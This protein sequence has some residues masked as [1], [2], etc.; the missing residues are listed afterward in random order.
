MKQPAV[1]VSRHYQA[2][3]G[4]FLGAIFIAHLQQGVYVL[5]VLLC[6]VGSLG[7]ISPGRIYPILM[8]AALTG[9]QLFHQLGSRRLGVPWSGGWAGLQ[10]EDVFLCL[11]VLGYVAAHYR[12]QSVAH[13]ILPLD[14][15]RRERA[16]DG[17]SRVAVVPQRR[18]A[19]QVDRKEI[20]MLVVVLPVWAILG[21]IFWMW[22]RD[23]SDLQ[24]MRLGP[25]RLVLATWL[26][27]MMSLLA[28]TLL[29][30]WRRR[31]DSPEIAAMVLQDIFW[32][33]TRREQRRIS[34]WLAWK[35]NV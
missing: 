31:Q 17:A 19:Q 1:P 11:S 10:V 18:P 33:E 9:T 25:T 30:A 2:L 16:D 14:R 4:L 5:T 7:V 35:R 29:G 22:L 8:L 6:L 26:L 23:P 21:Q 20:S 15:R 3:C 27:G 28:I 32:K 34:R 12:W 13:F 24:E